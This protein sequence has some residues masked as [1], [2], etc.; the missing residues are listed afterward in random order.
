MT[1]SVLIGKNKSDIDNIKK[2]KD[3]IDNTSEDPNLK[4]WITDIYFLLTDIHN[5]TSDNIHIIDQI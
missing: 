1:F 2:I 5:Y 4:Q 3:I